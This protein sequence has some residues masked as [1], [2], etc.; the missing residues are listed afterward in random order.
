M[1]GAVRSRPEDGPSSASSPS[2]S[3]LLPQSAVRDRRLFVRVASPSDEERRGEQAEPQTPPAASS[4]DEDMGASGSASAMATPSQ[5]SPDGGEPAA[6]PA[7]SPHAAAGGGGGFHQSGAASSA[8]AS[9]ESQAPAKRPASAGQP[10]PTARPRGAQRGGTAAETSPWVD[11]NDC[12][13]LALLILD[14]RRGGGD[15]VVLPPSIWAHEVASFLRF[16]DPLP[17]MLYA[18]GGRSQ[19]Q[20]PMSVVEMFDTWHGRWTRLQSM[21]TRRAGSAA[22][23]LPDG[24]MAVT[25][26]YNEHGIAEGLLASCELYNPVQRRWEPSG[27]MAP[28][29]RARWG[30][31]C[32]TLR[33]KV[34]VVGGCSLQAHTQPRESNME[35]LNSC[36][37]YDPVANRWTSVAPLNI[38]R[39]GARLVPLAGDRYLAAIGGC[40]DVFGR[41]ETQP[42]VELFDFETGVW[43]LMGQR[44]SQPRTTA[45]AVAIGDQEVF[46][47][48]GAPSLA[49]AELYRVTPPAA[50]SVQAGAAAEAAE[51][52]AEERCSELRSM[53]DMLEGRMGCQ[54][55]LVQLPAPGCTFPKT[56]RA[57]VVVIG[58]E[59]CDEVDGEFPRIKQFKCAPVLDVV[60]G[61]WRE[62]KPIPDMSAART[63]VA[64]CVGL[65]HAVRGG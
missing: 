1:I 15:R 53:P 31:G 25:G 29:L 33:G 62:D 9:K 20:G 41:A 43:T 16:G 14:D 19:R 35:T 8:D 51:A 28:L 13:A 21:P 24:R 26:G 23:V 12:N 2:A 22:A 55:A 49:S 58:G 4:H 45:A 44:L 65:G 59:R 46:I 54:A 57:S 10:L 32:T 63:A 60:T 17:N 50:A 47:V 42:T 37:V 7:M 38:P 6:W 48:G 36:E 27:T 52:A 11:A 34:Y 56:S 64:L 3:P 40:D 18:F 61:K 30:H 39:S 5:H